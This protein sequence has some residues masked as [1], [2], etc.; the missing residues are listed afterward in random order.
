MEYYQNVDYR[1]AGS[2]LS[3]ITGHLVRGLIRPG[4]PDG[5]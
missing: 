5:Y 3:V 1:A 2:L 4:V